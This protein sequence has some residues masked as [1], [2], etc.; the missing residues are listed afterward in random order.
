MQVRASALAGI[1]VW[2]LSGASALSAERA[3]VGDAALRAAIGADVQGED[4]L[5]APGVYG[6][7]SIRAGQAPAAIGPQDPADK[8]NARL[9]SFSDCE[10]LRVTGNRIKGE[11]AHVTVTLADG[12][13]HGIDL[14][15]RFCRDVMIK[16]NVIIN[17]QLHRITVGAAD[18][19]TVRDNTM[20]QNPASAGG[21]RRDRVWVPAT[22][23]SQASRNVRA[24][25]NVTGGARGF[26]LRAGWMARDNLIIQ[27]T[28]PGSPNHFSKM[29]A[30]WSGRDLA[31]ADTYRLR[32]GMPA[33]GAA[34]LRDN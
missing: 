6:R 26:R 20:V 8:L 17:D 1:L 13:G 25:G 28:S 4:L 9:F 24:F 18:D 11:L 16:N 14:L 34:Q 30:N 21:N 15:V 29:F 10:S 27:N 7:L 3:I 31:Q 12:R 33:V 32:S 5:L 22:R 2:G 23:L 19:L